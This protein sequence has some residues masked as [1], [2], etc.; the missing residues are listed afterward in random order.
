MALRITFCAAVLALAVYQF[1]E[2]T[3]DPDLWGHIVF[4][5]QV[6]RTGSIARTEPYSW[7]AHGQPWIN[8]EC[9]AELA[10]GGAHALLGGSGVLLLKMAVGLATFLICLRL[11]AEGL[12]WPA[13]Y[14][15]WGIG[16]LAVVEMSY[17][18]AA[19]PQIFTAL[20]LALELVLL[21]QVHKSR[22]L[23]ALAIPPLFALWINTHGGVLAGFGLL[24]LTALTSSAQ[25]IWN[26]YIRPGNQ[27]ASTAASP[28]IQPDLKTVATLW[29]ATAI[30]G[31]AL[32]VNPWKADLVR[33][34]IGSVLWMRP[35]IEE[36]NP[37]PLN[38]D[39][40]ALFILILL[41]VF[42]W[43]FSRRRRVWWELAASAVFALLAVRSVRNT[44]LCALVLLALVPP[45]L[46]D[47]LARF[48]EHLDRLEALGRRPAF[49]KA[50]IALL[51]I[52]TLSSAVATFTL[53][54]SHPLTMD[55]PN[56]E[57]PVTA[58]EFMRAHDLRGRVMV[59][60]DWGEML[61]YELPDCPPSIDGRLDTCYSRELIKAHWHFY[62]AEPYDRTL[63]DPAAADLA[64]LPPSLAGAAAL[65]KEPGWSAV[66]YDGTA[67]LLARNPDRF[68]TLH[69]IVLPVAG[70]VDASVGR[71]A[72]SD[73]NPRFQSRPR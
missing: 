14:T 41:A 66:Y 73:F 49:R 61:I 71:T 24:G 38:W 8:H 64:L 10:I 70:P 2:N 35:E 39:H 12:S 26:R 68:P 40:A 9:L 4:G 56:S 13:R 31:L 23:W 18:F 57:Y 48:R 37:T 5:R 62:N 67:V 50:A 29:I 63:L 32:L 25:A 43:A 30:S 54:K 34:L 17:G 19:R 59:F 69:G 60:F 16:A 15:T 6:L 53:H 52:S 45:H 21:R 55:V 28:A 51:A 20:A 1:S 11:G 58:V 22:T 44:P 3:A 33:W 47:S 36:W 42:A 27:P 65:S 7:T 46:A 72:F